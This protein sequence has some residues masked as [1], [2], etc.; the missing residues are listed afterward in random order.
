MIHRIIGVANLEDSPNSSVIRKTYGISMGST[1]TSA[2]QGGTTIRWWN[3]SYD[4]LQ[5]EWTCEWRIDFAW[6]KLFNCEYFMI[7]PSEDKFYGITRPRIKQTESVSKNKFDKMRIEQLRTKDVFFYLFF[8][9]PL[10]GAEAAKRADLCLSNRTCRFCGEEV[11][12]ESAGVIVGYWKPIWFIAHKECEVPGKQEEAFECQCIDADCNDCGYFNRGKFN[13]SADAKDYR[14]FTGDPEKD[15]AEQKKYIG[16]LLFIDSY[17]GNC[18]KYDRPAS[19]W[20]KS[21]RMLPCFKHRK[22][23]GRDNGISKA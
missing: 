12:R 3:D 13:K 7:D 15:A 10:G 11:S 9:D 20:P 21:A 4:Q 18:M 2:W 1:K 6:L 14:I 22:F 17:D 16:D 8:D 19:A 5:E 23:F